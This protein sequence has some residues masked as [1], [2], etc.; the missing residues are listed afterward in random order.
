MADKPYQRKVDE[1]LADYQDKFLPTLVAGKGTAESPFT[2]MSGPGAAQPVMDKTQAQLE[3]DKMLATSI[4]PD[5]FNRV[6]D[7]MKGGGTI[8]SHRV[9]P[10]TPMSQFS[11][12]LEGQRIM[13]ERA[14]PIP[15]VSTGFN[16]PIGGGTLQEF[17]AAIPPVFARGGN[18]INMT[19]GPTGAFEAEKPVPAGGWDWRGEL[20]NQGTWSVGPERFFLG[21][22]E[23]PAGTPGAVSGDQLARERIGREGG[24]A[25]PQ[26]WNVSLPG[27]GS[28]WETPEMNARAR[29]ES[30]S[31]Y[32]GGGGITSALG[33]IQKI[34]MKPSP[35]TDVWSP[36]GNIRFAGGYGKGHKDALV[37]LGGILAKMAETEAEKPYRKGMVDYYSRMAGV[38]EAELPSDIFYKRAMGEH[39]LKESLKP[40]MMPPGTSYQNLEGKWVT[41]PEKSEP[42]RAVIQDVYK[43]NFT[44]NPITGEMKGVGGVKAELRSMRKTMPELRDL[45]KEAYKET[46]AEFMD[47]HKKWFAGLEPKERKAY[48]K[49]HKGEDLGKLYK[50]YWEQD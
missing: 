16:P 3:R 45:P 46:K 18:A 12:T 26:G 23:V 19:P 8:P 7:V 27:G 40:W 39:A 1:F 38:K 28:Y 43:R 4:H 17:K 25:I 10:G 34:L 50:E 24:S 11:N 14:I 42:I 15:G 13:Q 22:K 41:A 44:P 2:N 37:G 30:E 31:M 29:A 48:E 49:K 6:L 9:Q 47:A 20:A 36:G 33:D 35:S 21:G 32:G 5:T